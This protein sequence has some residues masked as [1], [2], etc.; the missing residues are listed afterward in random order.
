M[1]QVCGNFLQR[2]CTWCIPSSHTAVS[3]LAEPN[4]EPSDREARETGCKRRTRRGSGGSGRGPLQSPY[5]LFGKQELRCTSETHSSKSCGYKSSGRA[6]SNISG[7]KTDW[8]I[9][10]CAG[11]EAYI[12]QKQGLFSPDPFNHH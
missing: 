2:Q 6:C 11:M 3:P 1:S 9:E 10:T 7:E 4:W 5:S 8:H 12:S